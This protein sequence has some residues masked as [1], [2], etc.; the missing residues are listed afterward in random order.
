VANQKLIEIAEA[1]VNIDY[2]G[3]TMEEAQLLAESKAIE[4]IEL[5][6]KL[7]HD[8][9]AIQFSLDEA[10]AQYHEHVRNAQ[11]L[12]NALNELDRQK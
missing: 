5:I 1:T 9:N 12:E 4:S 7:R 8:L 3:K 2:P 11:L 10:T 6:H